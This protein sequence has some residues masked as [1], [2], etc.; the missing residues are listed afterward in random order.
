MRG[1][2]EVLGVVIVLLVTIVASVFVILW[3]FRGGHE[4]ATSIMEMY[5]RGQVRQGELLSFVG[6]EESISGTTTVISVWVYNYGSQPVKIL[7][8]FI[9]NKTQNSFSLYDDSGNPV[10]SIKPGTMTKIVVN[11]PYI[12]NG[13]QQ[14]TF[15][16]FFIYT[17]D[18]LA[19]AWRIH[20]NQIYT[21]K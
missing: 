6:H 7:Y 11:V 15:Y 1:V 21:N 16:N 10:D 4:T 19:Y 14:G 18:D 2:S 5:Q 3:G 12:V 13:V 9:D 20:I 8:L 17:T